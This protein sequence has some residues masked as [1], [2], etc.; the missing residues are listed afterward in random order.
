MV[1]HHQQQQQHVLLIINKKE[2]LKEGITVIVV[3]G[4]DVDHAKR[5]IVVIISL[6]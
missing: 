1:Y 3:T 5:A 2:R 4:V 6:G